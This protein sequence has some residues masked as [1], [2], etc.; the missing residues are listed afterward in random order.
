MLAVIFL[1]SHAQPGCQSVNFII[2]ISWT[3]YAIHKHLSSFLGLTFI[4]R[5]VNKNHIYQ[6]R[7]TQVKTVLRKVA[8]YTMCYTFWPAIGCCALQTLVTICIFNVFCAK[9]HWQVFGCKLKK[10]FVCLIFELFVQ[11]TLKKHMLTSV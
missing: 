5:W 3:I 7:T 6:K 2:F 9:N 1:N 11:K 4:Y 10:T 8:G